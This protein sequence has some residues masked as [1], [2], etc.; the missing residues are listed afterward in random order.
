MDR[1]P[2]TGIVEEIGAS[3]KVADE[4]FKHP[5]DTKNNTN[6][7]SVDNGNDSD[8]G[9]IGDS[10]HNSELQQQREQVE[11]AK[12]KQRDREVRVHERAHSSA[13]GQHA[14]HPKYEYE[15]GTNGVLYAVGG[16]V[17]IDSSPIRDN[18]EATLAKAEQIRRA[19][20]A[21]VN[22]S[23]QDRLVAAQAQ[24]MAIEARAEISEKSQ[25]KRTTAKETEV[26]LDLQE[27][28]S[29]RD[30][31]IT[32]LRDSGAI[33]DSKSSGTLINIVA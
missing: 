33:D 8:T 30:E 17:S 15:R 13:G 31:L 12:L 1:I 18:P 22:P 23:T 7:Q 27:D 5:Q 4:A 25:T 16:E 20:L 9:S 11:L 10:E 6:N 26:D 14:G 32:H 24:R 29:V 28:E 21:P 19:A 3:H 2:Q